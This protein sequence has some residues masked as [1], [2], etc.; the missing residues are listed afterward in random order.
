[1]WRSHRECQ[2]ITWLGRHA[3]FLAQFPQCR[4]PGGLAGLAAPR[5]APIVRGDSAAVARL[6][7]SRQGMSCCSRTHTVTDAARRPGRVMPMRRKEVR[8]A[9]TA[10]LSAAELAAIRPC[11][12][13]HGRCCRGRLARRGPGGVLGSAGHV[14]CEVP[15]HDSGMLK[16][17]SP[18]R[19]GMTGTAPR[20][21]VA[22]TFRSRRHVAFPARLR[23]A[24]VRRLPP[25]EP[26]ASRADEH[27]QPGDGRPGGV[28][29]SGCQVPVITATTWPVMIVPP[30]P[31]GPARPTT[32][33]QWTCLTVRGS[34]SVAR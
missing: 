17:L 13:R 24:A 7:I 9:A 6:V 33:S 22:E 16:P 4:V 29:G 21:A 20:A 30:M 26:A 12:L 15:C 1:M 27:R 23:L 5:A 14:S 34:H 8:L 18:A 31:R 19:C 28:I 10:A 2:D 3:G 32:G 11:S 25:Q